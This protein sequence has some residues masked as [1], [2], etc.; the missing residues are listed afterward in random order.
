MKAVRAA[1]PFPEGVA[2]RA[3]LPKAKLG[4]DKVLYFTLHIFSGKTRYI[5]SLQTSSFS[6]FYLIPP[7]GSHIFLVLLRE[8]MAGDM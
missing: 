1:Y 7:P 6:S 5:A 3:A 2:V 4:Y 8:L